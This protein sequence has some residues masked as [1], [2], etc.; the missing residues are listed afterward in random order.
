MNFVRLIH[1][2]WIT[3][4][5]LEGALVPVLVFKRVW[6]T[7]PIFTVF[8][9]WD[10]AASAS[11]FLTVHQPSRYLFYILG[12][13]VSVGLALALT[14]EAFCHLFAAQAALRRLAS[15][16]MK[17]VASLLILLGITV[18][19][20]YG[21]FEQ[22]GLVQ[23]ILVVEESCLVLEVGLIMFLCVFSGAVGLH[24]R[25]QIFGIVLGLGIPASFRL[26][27][28]AVGTH[29]YVTNGVVNTVVLAS[30]I[31]GSLTWI[32]YMLLPDR[33]VTTSDVPDTSQL[34]QW[35]RAVMELIHQ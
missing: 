35:N 33:V 20:L 32:A 9:F 4:I 30:G 14:Y 6:R 3:G 26:A 24:W 13:A 28:V 5:A 21:P 7:F 8:V 25:R 15:I 10:V 11:F 2:L 31:L 27:A 34:E 16:L 18:I 1:W 22:K 19:V 29:S 12:E 23:G 17:I